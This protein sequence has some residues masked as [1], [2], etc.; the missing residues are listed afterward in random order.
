MPRG[1]WCPVA[2]FQFMDFWPTNVAILLSSAVIVITGN[3][4]G[5]KV[6]VVITSPTSKPNIV[7][8]KGK[9]GRDSLCEKQTLQYWNIQW[10][11]YLTLALIFRSV[12]GTIG[13]KMVLFWMM[14]RLSITKHHGSRGRNFNPLEIYPIFQHWGQ[15][16]VWNCHERD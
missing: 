15:V 5:R 4:E 12:L 7:E 6:T 3:E 11:S 2:T 10:L 9:E 13:E 16:A 1:F 8:T 14:K